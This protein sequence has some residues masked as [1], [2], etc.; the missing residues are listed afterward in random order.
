MAGQE[1]IWHVIIGGKE[2]G[3]LTKAQVLEYLAHGMLA[4]SDLIWRPG[5][6]DWKS[7]SEIG[8]FWQPPKRTSMQA[9]VQSRT[10]AQSAP[11]RVPEPDRIDAPSAGEKWSVWKSANIGLLVSAFV[12][13]VQIVTGRGFELANYAHTASAATI[14]GLVGQILTAPLI[15]VL[16][17]VV[18]N[19]LNR[20]QPK[21]SASAARGA[22]IFAALLVCIVGALMVYGEIF[23]ASTETISEETRKTMIADMSRKCVQKQRLL[24]QNMTEAQIA[25]YCTCVSEKIADGMTY[26]Q[27]GTDPDASA[28]ADL[29][30]KA[31]AAGYACR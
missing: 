6:P 5:F 28:L 23:F 13:L 11:E 17:T 19:L 2:Q 10:L 3:P 18:R 7:V 25:K 12:L 22:L 24:G 4:G 15:F 1:A 9:S 8:D 30:Q 27:L 14:S 16:I 29:K 21:S 26:K 20:R 31:E